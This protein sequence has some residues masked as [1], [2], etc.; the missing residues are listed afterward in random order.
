MS[1]NGITVTLYDRVQTGTDPFNAPI[2]SE[3]AEPVENVLVA[4]AT[5]GG[6]DVIDQQQLYSKRAEYILGIPKGDT[7]DW[8]DK[9][10]EFFGEKFRVFGYPSQGIED[11][12]PLSWNKKVLVERYE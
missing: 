11:N 6:Q 8:K 5:Q 1:I 2:Y 7:H 3:I 12:I 4:P 10:V 9:T